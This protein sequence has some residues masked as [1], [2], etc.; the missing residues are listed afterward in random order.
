[1]TSRQAAKSAISLVP[2]GWRATA[3][4]ASCKVVHTSSTAALSVAYTR[5]FGAPLSVRLLIGGCGEKKARACGEGLQHGRDKRYNVNGILSQPD[6]NQGAKQAGRE[7]R[8]TSS[9]SCGRE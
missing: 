9:L 3:K 4:P 6:S 7:A 2:S 1:M 5:I 8:R